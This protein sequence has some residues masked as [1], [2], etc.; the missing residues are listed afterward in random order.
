MDYDEI[1]RIFQVQKKQH[2]SYHE[3]MFSVQYAEAAEFWE[4]KKMMQNEKKAS[5]RKKKVWRW[6]IFAVLFLTISWFVPGIAWV[7]MATWK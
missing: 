3:Q 5:D 6:V 4:F 2:R 7:Y 1:D